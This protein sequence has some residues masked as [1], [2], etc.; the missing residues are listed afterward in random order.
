MNYE[1]HPP[2]IY[3]VLKDY[4]QRYPQLPLVVS[5]AGIATEV[6][7][8]RAENIVRTLEQIERARSEGADVR[9][10]YHWSLYDNF[11]W[12]EGYGPRFGLYRVDYSTYARTPTE[13]A[14]VLAQIA[15]SRR[16]P[17][18]LRAAHGGEGPLTPEHADQELPEMCTK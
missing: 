16:L 12:A 7:K 4:T 10:Y 8:R 17:E 18:A 2:G 11:E 5:E 9:G 13:G 3:T 6:G 14:T 15:G 1:Y